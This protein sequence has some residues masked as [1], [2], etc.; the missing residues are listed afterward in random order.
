ML[1]VAKI[2]MMHRDWTVEGK[3]FPRFP[4]II[5]HKEKQ[6]EVIV[7]VP[8]QPPISP[9][10]KNHAIGIGNTITSTTS[11]PSHP[12]SPQNSRAE[13]TQI[14][15][16]Q[17]IQK[18]DDPVIESS[19][20]QSKTENEHQ[21]RPAAWQSLKKK[22]DGVSQEQKRE[23]QET[24]EEITKTVIRS[25]EETTNKT[26]TPLRSLPLGTR[27][28]D[29][30]ELQF[31]SNEV[32]RILTPLHEEFKICLEI[33]HENALAKGERKIYCELSVLKR[34]QA[35]TLAQNNGILAAAAVGLPTCSRLHGIG[36]SLL[37]QEC[38]VK[39]VNVSAVETKCGY[40]PIT[41]YNSENYTIGL[42]GWS[43]HP[44]TPCFWKSDFVHLNGKSYHWEYNDTFKEWVEQKP[45]VHIHSLNLIAQFEEIPLKDYDFALKAH[46]V[47]EKSDL[48]Q[49]NVLNEL[50]GRMQDSSSNS[51]AQLVMSEKQ[52]NNITNLFSWTNALKIMTLVVIGFIL[53]VAFIMVMVK[54][55]PIGLLI[56]KIE[57]T[58]K[59][60]EEPKEILTP[61]M[62]TQSTAPP[63]PMTTMYP[64]LSTS[65][66]VPM[67]ILPIRATNIQHSHNHPTY[68]AG[69]GLVWED[70]CPFTAEY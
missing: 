40:E 70:N 19:E 3:S 11:K 61:M 29:K 18:T 69:R 20:S 36:Q 38:S 50:I 2:L 10:R 5:V 6:G 55:N 63:D 44:F 46:P 24:G 39:K 60:R 12:A 68:V 52:D 13:K 8:T 9:T 16:K 59:K 4:D 17:E 33:D 15:Q 65:Q 54:F 30:Y 43:L 7:S 28:L 47:Y 26:D 66:T 48:E 42:D 57:K 64:P 31:L 62:P 56:S 21:A 49:M 35:V 1:T 34:M 67:E 51:L 25:A 45:N 41:M 37:L 27:S 53:F 23:V 14:E 32:L 58:R 22:L